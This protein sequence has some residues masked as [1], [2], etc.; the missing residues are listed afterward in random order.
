MSYVFM[1]EM[2]GNVFVRNLSKWI[3]D[4]NLLKHPYL[5]VR[6]FDVEK[7][8]KIE[9]EW[10]TSGENLEP[11]L[12][13]TIDEMLPNLDAQIP[14]DLLLKVLDNH[15]NEAKKTKDFYEYISEPYAASRCIRLIG[16]H[17]KGGAYEGWSEITVQV[18]EKYK[19][20]WKGS[21]KDRSRVL[22]LGFHVEKADPC[23]LRKYLVAIQAKQEAKP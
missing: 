14:R 6:E 1:P 21:F 16:Q 23:P 4:N 13:F 17:Y 5:F 9:Y 22:T 20:K 3:D 15:F 7:A 11:T 12:C 19:Q 10:R 18:V 2:V 8:L